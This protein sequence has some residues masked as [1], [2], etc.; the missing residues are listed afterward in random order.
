MSVHENR[1]VST[2]LTEA[3]Y[4][5]FIETR[6]QG[7][8]IE[9]NGTTVAFA[10][11]DNSN[12]SIWALFVAPGHEGR[13]YGRQLHDE[14]ESWLWSQ[15][16]ERLWLTT[17]PGTRAQRFYEAAGWQQV[18]PAAHGEIRMELYQKGRV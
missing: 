5:D 11:A 6:G 8:L 17:N 3:D 16:H 12:G 13:G 10:I 2:R 4:I 15:G 9:E 14:M 1:L 7:W 18:G